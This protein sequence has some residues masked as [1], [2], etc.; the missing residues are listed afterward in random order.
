MAQ[1]TNSRPN[2]VFIFIE[3]FDGRKIGFWGN[4]A[5]KNATP[6]MDQIAREGCI[7][8]NMYSTNP[9]CCPVRANLWTGTYGFRHQS[10]NNHKGLKPGTK[11]FQHIL[12][13]EGYVFGSK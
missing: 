13:E 8:S 6:H 3:S 2:I 7:F 9:I 4:P 5:L 1:N 12:E 11:R 10:W